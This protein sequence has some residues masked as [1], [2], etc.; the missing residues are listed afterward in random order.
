MSPLERIVARIGGDLYDG[1]RR[2]LVPGPGHGS[3]DRSV[4][5]LVDREGRVIVHC[6]SPRDDWR[7]VRD[8]LMARGLLGQGEV[9]RRTSAPWTRCVGADSHRGARREDRAR[10]L[11]DEGRPVG[12][13][14][15]ERYLRAR[16][17]DRGISNHDA[18]RFHPRA[19]SIED[20]LRRP[21]LV[22]AIRSSAGVV[23]GVEVTL[24]SADGCE[25]AA[26]TTPRRIVGRLVGG[27]VHLD[28]GGETL[29]VGEGVATVLS[30]SEVLGLEA[31]AL[32]SGHNLARFVPPSFVRVLVIAVDRDRAGWR[33]AQ[34]LAARIGQ[35][36]GVEFAPPPLGFNDWN[37]YARAG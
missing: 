20:R 35:G 15:G 6:F 36:I 25:K 14:L 22:A 18:V 31:W 24:L 37:D 29:L 16:G 11:W 4:S 21:A 8:A 33:A 23:Q 17:I 12:G 27:A 28:I 34:R 30:A 32:L 1:G 3:H 5:L 26:V 2:A 10:R 19:S 13:T 9:G 7:D